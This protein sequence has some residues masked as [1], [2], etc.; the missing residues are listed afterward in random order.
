MNME[1]WVVWGPRKG[2]G[3]YVVPH[4]PSAPALR[5]SPAS[6]S[7]ATVSRRVISGSAAISAVAAREMA[8]TNPAESGTI[9]VVETNDSSLM[10]KPITSC[11]RAEAGNILVID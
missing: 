9:H 2:G 6:P 1:S 4:V 10:V 8:D 7:P 3:V 5:V 11:S